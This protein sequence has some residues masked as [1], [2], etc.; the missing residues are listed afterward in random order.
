MPE[1][2]VK[3]TA[4]GDPAKNPLAGQALQL[5]LVGGFVY[6]AAGNQVARA[7]AIESP[8]TQMVA[9]FIGEMDLRRMTAGLA[10]ALTFEPGKS[11]EVR[12]RA[13]DAWKQGYTRLLSERARRNPRSK[14]PDKRLMDLGP[15]DV[16]QPAALPNY[17]A[18]YDN[19]GFVADV[20]APP[21]LVNKPNDVYYT[22][23]KEDAFQRAMPI[24]GAAGG[25]VAEVQPRVANTSFQTVEYAIGGFIEQQLEAAADPAL[26]LRQA[27]AQRIYKILMIERELRVATLLTTSGNYDSS[28]VVTLAAGSQWNGGASSDPVKDIHGRVEAAWADDL[29]GTLLN[30]QIMHSLQR[31]PAVQAYIAYKNGIAPLPKSTELGALLE[32]PPFY[33]AKAKYINSSGNLAY[34]WPSTNVAMF[35]MPGTMPPVDQRDVSTAVTFRWNDTNVPDGRVSNG[36]VIREYYLNHRGSKGGFM[37]MMIHQDAE[38]V[39]S[40][41]AGGLI[42]SAYQ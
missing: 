19:G 38:A 6:D 39:T 30:Q 33:E 40:K 14:D 16:H 12:E 29:S 21:I 36:F 17:A 35:R 1:H 23:A 3:F 28:V 15:S 18:G 41:F 25:Q 13:K 37:Q 11:E 10:R 22:F 27:F 34:I 5:D 26:K 7:S 20:I 2:V 4:Q 8:K 24:V 42:V 9:D 32:L 31:N